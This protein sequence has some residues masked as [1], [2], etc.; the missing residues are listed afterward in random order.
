MI[1]IRRVLFGRQPTHRPVRTALKPASRFFAAGLEQLEGRLLMNVHPAGETPHH[2]H[3]HLAIFI[4]GQNFVIP[5]S[6]GNASPGPLLGTANENAHTH[7]N[8]GILHYNEATPAFRDL[9]EF[10]DTWGAIFNQNELKLPIA[11]NSS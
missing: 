9:K 11:Y 2:I 4:D 6:I 10:F 1:N 5:A 7:T 8:D 3:P